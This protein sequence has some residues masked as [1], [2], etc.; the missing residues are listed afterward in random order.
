MGLGLFRKNKC[1]NC[2]KLEQESNKQTNIIE[3]IA[4]YIGDLALEVNYITGRIE[5]L[6]DRVSKQSNSFESINE[7]SQKAAIANEVIDNQA[8]EARSCCEKGRIEISESAAAIDS[9]S[10]KMLKLS[11]DINELDA[12]FESLSDSIKFFDKSVKSITSIAKQTRLLALNATIEAARAGEAGHG[13]AVVAGEVQKL[14][15]ETSATTTDI[16]NRVSD[17][18]QI[19]EYL[20]DL[21][22]SASSDAKSTLDTTSVL[23]EKFELFQSVFSDISEKSS[24]I[25][26]RATESDEQTHLIAEEI[27]KLAEGLNSSAEDINTCREQVINFLGTTDSMLQETSTVDVNT[28]DTP[29]KNLCISGA[30]KIA[31]LLN[32][33][34]ADGDTTEEI[35]FSRDYAPI[36]NTNP[37]QHDWPGLS[38]C[39][40]VTCP[41][42]N[43]LASKLEG[44]VSCVTMIPAAG[45]DAYLATNIEKFSHRP[46]GDFK[47]DAFHCRNKKI[48]T[49]PV[50]KGGIAHRDKFL[51][52]TYRANMGVDQNGEPIWWLLKDLT[53]P[54]YVNKKY[55]GCFRI[56]YNT[57]NLS[58]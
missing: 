50:S 53:S 28:V 47:H 23:R 20:R 33:G 45:K 36:H 30:N 41:I 40:K 22:V 19:G 16:G 12:K 39:E 29:F 51:L 48:L 37:Q 44:I 6:S 27:N 21:T 3:N 56:V 43:D 26:R 11:Q 9:T 31:D 58:R 35:L 2:I 38:F 55:W 52:K 1:S 13:F 57:G 10:E 54:I 5:V 42:L 25:E 32:K 24:E 7:K 46:T 4:K 15:Q 17:L 8:H 18:L 34:I 49:D 14:A